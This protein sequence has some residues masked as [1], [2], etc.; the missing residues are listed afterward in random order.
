MVQALSNSMNLQV[1][2]VLLISQ[3]IYFSFPPLIS[4]FSLPLPPSKQIYASKPSFANKLLNLLS[5]RMSPL[6]I[7]KGLEIVSPSFC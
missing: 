6:K 4:L 7:H 1:S 5:N 3:Y 2:V